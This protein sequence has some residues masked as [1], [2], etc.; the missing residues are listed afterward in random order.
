MILLKIQK[1]STIKTFLLFVREQAKDENGRTMGFVNFGPVSFVKY[2]GSQPM[3]ITWKL[4]HP[5][6]SFMWHD[7][8]KL[9]MS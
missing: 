2:E 8:A 9:A 1:V 5:M 6:P 4:A 7:T 3:N